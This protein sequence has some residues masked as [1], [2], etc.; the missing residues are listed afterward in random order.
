[1]YHQYYCFVMVWTNHIKYVARN[2]S[3]WVASITYGGLKN[4]LNTLLLMARSG[5]HNVSPLCDTCDGDEE[6][7]LVDATSFVI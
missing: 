4:H 7:V 3:Y 5:V 1:M 2:L 6:L